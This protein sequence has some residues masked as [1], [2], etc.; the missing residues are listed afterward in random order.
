MLSP[1]KVPFLNKLEEGMGVYLVA[2]RKFVSKNDSLKGQDM[3]PDAFL[4]D[5]SD[6][7]KKEIRLDKIAICW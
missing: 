1:I 4:F 7:K 5:Q 2:I 6:I 3:S